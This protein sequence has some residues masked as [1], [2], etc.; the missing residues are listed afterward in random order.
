MIKPLP[1]PRVR[2]EIAS[3]ESIKPGTFFAGQGRLARQPLTWFCVI[4]FLWGIA[5]A[6]PVIDLA[7]LASGT[8][9]Y[10]HIFLIP[11]V[12][13]YLLWIKRAR[14]RAL[15]NPSPMLAGVAFAL[16]FAV[17]AGYWLA[18]HNGWRPDPVDYL[19]VTIS[20][21]LLMVLGTV[22]L[23][24]G[25]KVLRE[26]MFAFAFLVFIIPLPSAVTHAIEKFFQ[27]TSA[28]ASYLLF[29]ALG[30][31]VFQQGLSFSLP[32]L[33][34]TVAEEC[35]GIRSSFV[36]F[37]TSLLAGHL[38]L[39]RP[40]KRAVLTLAVIP[41]GIIRNAI[42]IVSISLLTIHVDSN[43]ING[44]LHHRGGPLFFLLSLVPFF[45]FLWYLRKGE[46]PEK[47]MGR[48]LTPPSPPRTGAREQTTL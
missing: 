22:A 43:I 12:T 38:F 27:H 47:E 8:E 19:S 35:S 18:G 23:V 37:I 45:L 32:G 39:R 36:L 3:G 2:P 30:T 41:L 31:P 15:I 42:R 34:I 28:E 11:A 48:P 16:G 24:F 25:G 13:V 26:G 5:F 10:S 40:W 20:S 21:F 1:G 9:L 29:K 14:L 44:P 33:R 7:R 17:L 6:K 46:V 4:I